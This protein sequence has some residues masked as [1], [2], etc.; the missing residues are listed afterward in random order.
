MDE[1]RAYELHPGDIFSVNL[2]IFMSESTLWSR[3]FQIMKFDK[4]KK[5]WDKLIKEMH[6]LAVIQQTDKGTYRIV[7]NGIR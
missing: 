4:F 3:Q 7:H 6:C 2:N 1:V 5:D